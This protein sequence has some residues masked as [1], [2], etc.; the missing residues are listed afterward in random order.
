MDAIV[1]IN[2]NPT[3][4][5]INYLT[6]QKMAFLYNALEKGW[7]INK[8]NNKYIFV[9]KHE[10]KKEVFLDN[11]LQQFIYQNLDINTIL[12]NNS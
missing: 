10:E 2:N 4:I 1:N 3:N 7:Q 6:F 12:R 9:K 8:N 11:Y 5:K